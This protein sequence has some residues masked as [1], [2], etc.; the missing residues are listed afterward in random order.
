MTY[1]LGIGKLVPVNLLIL[2]LSDGPTGLFGVVR[3]NALSKPLP[4]IVACQQR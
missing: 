4:G 2:M 1:G 3:S